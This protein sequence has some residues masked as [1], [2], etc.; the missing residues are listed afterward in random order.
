MMKVSDLNDLPKTHGKGGKKVDPKAEEQIDGSPVMARAP[1]SRR[2]KKDGL[3]KIISSPKCG[4]TSDTNLNRRVVGGKDAEIGAHPW[5]VAI[6][7]DGE[8][9]CG[10]SIINKRWVRYKL[11][12]NLF[13]IDRIIY[14]YWRPPIV[15]WGDSQ[16]IFC[17]SNWNYQ[18]FGLAMSLNSQYGQLGWAQSTGTRV[19]LIKLRKVR[20]NLVILHQ[21][22]WMIVQW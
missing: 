2:D 22:N 5:I 9:W 3:G 13:V 20:V 10:G 16:I 11:S 17:F 7:K 8:A 6:L 18:F 21:I 4:K 15:L 19:A 14:R 1:V 12:E